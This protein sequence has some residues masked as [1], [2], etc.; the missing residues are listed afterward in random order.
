MG[1]ASSPVLPGNVLAC[2]CHEVADD[3]QNPSVSTLGQSEIVAFYP[4]TTVTPTPT[5]L[6]GQSYLEPWAPFLTHLAA[7]WPPISAS[8]TGP[9]R[10][11]DPHRPRVFVPGVVAITVAV[12]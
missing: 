1:K 4:W 12:T 8:P 5:E 11:E 10:D 2:L 9:L 7:K 3:G 6:G